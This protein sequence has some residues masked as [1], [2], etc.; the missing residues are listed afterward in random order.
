M[1]QILFY[2][3]KCDLS[4]LDTISNIII[5]R[6]YKWHCWSTAFV[7]EFNKTYLIL[8]F[9]ITFA[10]NNINVIIYFKLNLCC[11]FFFSCFTLIV[12]CFTKSL[13]F[14]C[15]VRWKKHTFGVRAGVP[16]IFKNKCLSRS[17]YCWKCLALQHEPQND[18]CS[19]VQHDAKAYIYGPTMVTPMS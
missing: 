12:F 11:I 9:S 7:K 18:R 17:I 3:T 10:I 2:L 4:C 1:L 15:H 19:R 6:R 14:Q 16:S 5:K 13:F 8:C